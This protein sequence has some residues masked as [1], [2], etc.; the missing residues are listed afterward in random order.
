MLKVLGISALAVLVLAVAVTQLQPTLLLHVPEIGFVLYSM[1][2][3]SSI[4]PYMVEA[5]VSNHTRFRSLVRDGDV[6]AVSGAKM[7]THW[8]MN[9]VCMREC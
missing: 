9:V 4:P 8:L 2:T 5:Y 3:K 7:G 1:A 6:L